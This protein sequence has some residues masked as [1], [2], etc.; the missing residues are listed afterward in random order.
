L[1]G[2]P[3]AAGARVTVSFVWGQREHK[4]TF[5]LLSAALLMLQFVCLLLLYNPPELL[6]STSAQEALDC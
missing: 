5:H 4:L 6:G 1:Q 2:R 3:E